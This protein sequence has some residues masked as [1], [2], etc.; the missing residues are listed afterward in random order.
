MDV[1]KLRISRRK[2]HSGLHDGLKP[3]DKYSCKRHTEDK[4]DTWWVG[5]GHV[6]TE[7]EVGGMQPQPKG[8]LE[9]LEAGKGR[10]RF[11]LEPSEGAW[12]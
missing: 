8:Y 10:K 1:I 7:A 4:T 3:N 9:P 5:G 6:K 12:P 2:D 11:S